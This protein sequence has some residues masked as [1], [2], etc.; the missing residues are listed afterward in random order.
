M[1]VNARRPFMRG[2]LEVTEIS[3]GAAPL[4]NRFAPM[5]ETVA[6]DLL[7]GA[8]DAGVRYFD[9]AP[10]YGNGLSEHRVGHFLSTQDRASAVISTKVGRTLI[11]APLGSFDAG[12][13]IDAA[14]FR[15]EYDYTY[16]A[17]MRQLHDSLQRMLTDRVDILY[18]HDCDPFIL[19]ADYEQHMATA[20]KGAIP[21]MISLREQ[22]VV[23]AV[24]AGLNATVALERVVS[25]TDLDCLL[26]A[27]R[28]SLLDHSEARTFMEACTLRG[29]TVIAA[30]VF[31]TGVLAS[32]GGRFNYGPPP[33]A[34]VERV[35]RLRRH[36]T[37]FGV[38]L[39]AAAIQ[40]AGAHPAV[41][42]VC[43]GASSVAQQ[44]SN[45]ACVS[46]RIPAGFW[47]ALRS[48]GLVEDW[49]PT[50]A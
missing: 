44:E 32:Q 12:P 11:P 9:T 40:F 29:I 35:E 6:Q 33:E 34:I 3:F 8:W 5:P 49:A 7:R 2:G 13:W 30:G 24:G 47:A 28:Y 50:P 15:P 23:S 36:C 37:A 39:T 21:A 31:N 26:V 25:E 22:G 14:P 1:D 17:T 42:S 46:E 43:L 45:L 16:D 18:L 4:G 48:D 20:L 27:G 41:A 10:S 38:T 19:G